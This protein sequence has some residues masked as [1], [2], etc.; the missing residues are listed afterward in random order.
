VACG[1]SDSGGASGDVPAEPPS[2]EQRAAAEAADVFFDPALVRP[3]CPARVDAAQYPEPELVGLRLGMTRAEALA[4]AY[5]P[6]REFHV[7]TYNRFLRLDTRGEELRPQRI[8]IHDGVHVTR[9]ETSRMV[10]LEDDERDRPTL[11]QSIGARPISEASQVIQIATPGIPGQERVLGIWRQQ[12][13]DENPP[14]YE[15]TITSLVERFGQPGRDEHLQSNSSEFGDSSHLYWA[16]DT[17]GAPM[18]ATNP[19]FRRCTENLRPTYS[20]EQRW[21]ENCGLTIVAYVQRGIDNRDLVQSY[22]VAIMN[23]QVMFQAATAMR[24]HYLAAAQAEREA[25]VERAKGAAAPEL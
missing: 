17:S 16:Y 8:T 19:Q 3:N 6:R 14:T 15:A 10:Y 5:C 18:T 24:Q 13:F 9:R 1:Q 25:E 11:T 12:R 7:E 2:A 23:Q 22:S 21:S 4:V 20:V